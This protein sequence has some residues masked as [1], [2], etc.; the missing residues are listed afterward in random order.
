LYNKD[1][2]GGERPVGVK[3]VA[4]TKDSY[5]GILA[6]T[7]KEEGAGMGRL[8]M[9][10]RPIVALQSSIEFSRAL[11]MILE[12]HLFEGAV[13]IDPTPGNK[14]SWKFYLT[15]LDKRQFFPPKKFDIQFIPDDITTFQKTKEYVEENGPADAVYYDPPYLFDVSR[16]KNYST[17]DRR[18]KDYGGYH[19]T[20]DEV[21]NFVAIANEII[22]GFLKDTGLLFF[23]YTDVFS[24]VE[25]KYY[26]C[27]VLWPNA[28]TNFEI[29]DHYIVQHHHLSPTAWQVKDRP[30]GV[31]NYTYLTVFR[32]K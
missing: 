26:P 3:V 22:P 16:T 27:F 2:K 4:T 24:L 19:Y 7:R 12:F 10:K 11:Q 32:P 5:K 20:F 18:V 14:H 15:E 13:I 8:I 28:M 6:L 30:C 21:K 1:E 25:R 23:K 9:G 31:V 17:K 29:V